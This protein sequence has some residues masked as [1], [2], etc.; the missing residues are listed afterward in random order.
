[1]ESLEFILLVVAL[2]GFVCMTVI[3]GSERQIE[4]VTSKILGI[5]EEHVKAW[6]I[7]TK[8]SIKAVRLAAEGLAGVV[9]ALSKH[10]SKSAQ[11]YEA[12]LRE[13]EK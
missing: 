12:V 5:Q 9:E 13:F 11:H 4:K 6:Q 8:E 3:R 7:M 2:S 1:M 10:D